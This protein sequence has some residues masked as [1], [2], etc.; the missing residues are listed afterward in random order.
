MLLGILERIKAHDEIVISSDHGYL[1]VKA[2][3]AWPTPQ[4]YYGYLKDVMGARAAPISDS[5]KARAL[6]EKGMIVVH[7]DSFLVKGRY[8]G[9]FGGVYLHRGL[10][11]MECL[12]PWLVVQG[13]G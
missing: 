5:K 6:L 11:L 13:V 8:T 4:P 10:S 1:S 12:T 3:M 9:D 2:G 7:E